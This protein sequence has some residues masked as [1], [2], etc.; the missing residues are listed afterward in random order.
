MRKWVALAFAA[1]LCVG[2]AEAQ[3]PCSECQTQHTNCSNQAW[4][5]F[6]G[7]LTAAWAAATS[8][9]N[10]AWFTWMQCI[11]S[12]TV[13]CF[14]CDWQRDWLLS[15]CAYVADQETY[16]CENTFY[17]TQSGCSNQ[18]DACMATCSN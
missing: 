1:A 12:C 17:A 10:D 3:V 8:C 16:Y 4:G 18:R 5:V 14:H 15:T 6:D 2:S 11:S 9:N 7:C 13:Y